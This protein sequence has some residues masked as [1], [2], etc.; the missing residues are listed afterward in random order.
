MLHWEESFSFCGIVGAK[1]L[2][3]YVHCTGQNSY[4]GSFSFCGVAGAMNLDD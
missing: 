4:Q 3:K 1:N 2:D